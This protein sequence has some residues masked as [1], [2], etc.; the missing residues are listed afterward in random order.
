MLISIVYVCVVYFLY[1][2]ISSSADVAL[3]L[4]SVVYISLL[5]ASMSWYQQQFDAHLSSS[6]AQLFNV[7][8]TVNFKVKYI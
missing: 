1:W 5:R 6:A 2:Y 8:G 3:F 4:S 7:V